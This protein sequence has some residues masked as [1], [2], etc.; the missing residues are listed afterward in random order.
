MEIFDIG[1]VVHPDVESIPGGKMGKS[2]KISSLNHE[3]R[4]RLR[5]ILS[6]CFDSNQNEILDENEQENL[7]QKAGDEINQNNLETFYLDKSE[8]KEKSGESADDYFKEKAEKFGNDLKSDYPSVR[9]KA[10]DGL[11]EMGSMAKYALPQILDILKNNQEYLD[12]RLSALLLLLELGADSSDI[13]EAK[14][15]IIQ[16]LINNLNDEDLDVRRKAIDGLRNLGSEAKA[17]VPVFVKLLHSDPNSNVHADPNPHI[18]AGAVLALGKI[19]MCTKEVIEVLLSALNDNDNFVRSFAILSLLGIK[20][21]PKEIGSYI[22]SK[23]HPN[24]DRM[25]RKDAADALGKIGKDLQ[26]VAVPALINTLKNDPYKDVCISAAKALGDIGVAGNDVIEALTNALNDKEIFAAAAEAL[27]K[28]G[29]GGKDAVSTIVKTLND[30]NKTDFDRKEAANALGGIGAESRPAKDALIRA[31]KC[32]IEIRTEALKALGKIILNIFDYPA[33]EAVVDMLNDDNEKIR[34]EAAKILVSINPPD[35]R[36]LEKAIETGHYNERVIVIR[37][38]GEL[39]SSEKTSAKHAVP[40]LINMI[41]DKK[42]YQ[43]MRI[44]AVKSLG[45][46][47]GTSKECES[48]LIILLRDKADAPSVRMAALD[49]L[50]NT[51]AAIEKIINALVFVMLEDYSCPDLREAA[52]AGLEKRGLQAKAAIPALI[53]ALKNDEN[54]YVRL[55]AALALGNM[56]KEAKS[57]VNDLAPCLFREEDD[58]VRG[59]V[60][61]T[62]GKIG[63]DAKIAVGYLLPR[64][65]TDRSAV[66]K[67]NAALALG[68]IGVSS[69]A[70]LA[71]LNNTAGNP[72]EDHNVKEAAKEALA[73]LNR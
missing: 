71:A 14:K 25:V 23:L 36:I 62:L 2:V 33:A 49:V 45:Q 58:S 46:I 18:R 65:K 52:A 54:T 24:N 1:R 63:P 3:A 35:Y 59:A 69:E 6:R 73:M 32:N 22:V 5:D 15:E 40:A 38:L 50:N 34:K 70:V 68:K 11:T 44:E 8:K 28:L 51:G 42:E 41:K 4:E 27:G 43:H 56:G 19:G 61:E 47:D 17:A 16:A 67:C 37:K 30:A 29:K 39:G 64:L 57:V 20:A 21:P 7:Y 13:A 12:I 72:E 10:I 66:V 31:L 55:M 60:A 48:A 26:D 9:R 53:I